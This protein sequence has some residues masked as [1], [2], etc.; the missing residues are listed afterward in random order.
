[1]DNK[2]KQK[3]YIL[4]GI[5]GIAALLVYYN[6]LLRPQFAGFIV[7]NREFNAVRLR[8]KSAKAMIVNR[9]RLKTEYAILKEES[10]AF[11]KK[12]PA[13]QEISSLLEGLSSIA[14]ASNVTILKIKP[15][16][17]IDDTSKAGTLNQP[18]LKFPILIEAKAGYHQLGL[19]VNKLECMERFINIDDIDI[20]GNPAEPRRHDM[21]LR[22][23]TY[24]MR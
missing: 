11:S 18:Y 6:L 14:E 24:I 3:R 23:S 9:E 13:Q 15:I 1:M 21:R 2:E 19:F 12:L 16:E 4:F 22:V 8:V 7:H 17:V 10:V 20:R 5:F